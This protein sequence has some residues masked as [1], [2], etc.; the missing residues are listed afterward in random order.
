MTSQAEIEHKLLQ[1]FTCVCV[2]KDGG[3][4]TYNFLLKLDVILILTF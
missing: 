3:T 2:C 1:C 4:M